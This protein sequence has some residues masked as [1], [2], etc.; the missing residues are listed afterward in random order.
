[1]CMN[2]AHPR[3]IVISG[4]TATGKSDF[5][6]DLAKKINGEVISI[7][8]RQMYMG[9]DLCSGKI[10][11]E[12]MQGVP[13]HLLS[14][15]PMGQVISVAEVRQIA[16]QIISEICSRGK[17]PILCGGTGMYI[18]AITN[19]VILPHVTP[20]EELRKKLQQLPLKDLQEKLF[21]LDPHRYTTIDTQNPRRLIRAIEIAEQ[22]GSVPGISYEKKYDSLYIY[23]DMPDDILKDRIQRRIDQRIKNGMIE[24][25]E[26]LMT[27]GTS[28]ETL[29]SLGLEYAHI[30]KMLY[31]K[32]DV[33]TM[34]KELFFAIWHYAKRQRVWWKKKHIDIVCNPLIDQERTQAIAHAQTWILK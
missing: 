17:I 6:V 12:E 23:L 32:T 20:N 25:V 18:D 1:M 26:S 21:S 24:E 14:M 9:G 5:A 16:E 8:S 4:P 11:Q 33:E 31:E 19:G 10:T 7:D 27:Q 2:S 28:Y 30:S 29:Q 15:F 22:L 34:R 3:L 13:H